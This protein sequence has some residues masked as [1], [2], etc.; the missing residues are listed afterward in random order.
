MCVGSRGRI[1][2]EGRK[3]AVVTRVDY[4][5]NARDRTI[6]SAYSVRPFARAQ[7][8]C[9]IE[10]DEL[11]GLDPTALTISSVPT[12]FA[13]HDPWGEVDLRVETL[14]SLLDLARRDEAGGLGDAPWP[15]HF[16][17]A[18]GEPARVQP[19]RRKRA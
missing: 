4:N 12:R 2:D 8:S 7:V 14:D 11:D 3:R 17:K 16:P 13:D 6:A 19:S 18:E 10:W 5:Q 9:P 15:P 1:P